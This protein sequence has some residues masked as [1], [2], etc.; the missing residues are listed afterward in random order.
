MPYLAGVKKVLWLCSWYPNRNSAQEGDFIQRMAQA[1]ARQVPVHVLFLQGEKGLTRVEEIVKKQDGLTEQWVYYPETPGAGRW[2]KWRNYNRYQRVAREHLL[3]YFSAEGKPDLVHVQV[4]IRAG[5]LALWIQK[6]FGVP[7]A[8]TEHYGIYNR[9][10][11]DPF[12]KRNYFF[13]KDVE[14]ILRNA[15]PLICVSRQLG[16]DIASLLGPVPFRFIPNVVDTTLFHYKQPAAAAHPFRFLHVSNMLPLKNVEGILEAAAMLDA[17]GVR[18]EL[19]IIGAIRE[20][21][22]ELARSKKLL[23]RCVF[24][25]GEISYPE[26]AAAMQRADAL[27]MFSRSESGSCVVEEALCCGLPVLATPV[28]VARDLIV[29]AN[30]LLCKVDAVEELADKMQQLMQQEY[31]HSEISE[32]AMAAFSYSGIG[33]Q[34]AGVYKESLNGLR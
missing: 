33:K 18:F 6:K 28:G 7:Y 19:H 1:V 14:Q 20:T 23:D 24:F 15:S 8:L 29:P 11:T 21:V 5:R 12:E 31:R 22:R 13:K 25:S 9:V 32:Q 17:R 4:P 2:S 10:V 34:I 16:E 26:V 3:K 27:L 30:G